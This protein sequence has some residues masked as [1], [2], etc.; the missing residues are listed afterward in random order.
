[1]DRHDGYR[2]RD[3]DGDHFRYSHRTV[4]RPD[5]D[6]VVVHHYDRGWNWHGFY[7]YYVGY[8]WNWY[9]GYGS[10]GLSW[11][12]YAWPCWYDAP[13]CVAYVPFGFY[14]DR[15]PVL[16]R[17][18]VVE[19]EVPVVVVQREGAIAEP[20]PEAAED[21]APPPTFD[22][23]PEKY[24]REGS[25]AFATADYEAAA[26]SFRM[27]VIANPDSAAPKFAFGQALLALGDYAYASRVLREALATETEILNAPGSI[28]GV[29]RD[30]EEF[31]RVLSELKTKQL[32]KKTDPDLLFLVL[33]EHYFSGDPQAVVSLDRLRE[34]WPEDPMVA[35]F[36]PVTAERFPEFSKFPEPKTDQK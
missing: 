1:V 15:E 5:R 19:R 26:K 10:L 16:V 17:E 24:L 33:Y 25:E 20:A 4:R 2:D 7:G 6:V 31:F 21:I 14:V 30:P 22:A 12:R 3:H 29:Y 8:S 13:V 28:V 36:A 35:L 23:T 11:G 9:F 18:I 34:A 27:A 32:E